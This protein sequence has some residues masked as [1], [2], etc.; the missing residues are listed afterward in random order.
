MATLEGYQRKK[1]K[2]PQQF[3]YIFQKP[4]LGGDV[5]LYADLVHAICNSDQYPV[6]LWEDTPESRIQAATIDAIIN[7]IE[8]CPRYRAGTLIP[9][10]QKPNGGKKH[11]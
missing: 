8:A 10:P 11:D 9:T 7:A 6:P 1:P 5:I 2:K 3:N 4:W